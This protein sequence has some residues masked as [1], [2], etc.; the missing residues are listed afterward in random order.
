M[1]IK[2]ITLLASLFFGENRHK[3]TK[4]FFPF[5]CVKLTGHIVIKKKE[6]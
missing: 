6:N 5:C 2:R 4:K 3:H 1:T